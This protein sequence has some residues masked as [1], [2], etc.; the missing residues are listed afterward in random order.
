MRKTLLVLT[1]VILAAVPLL[2]SCD[3]AD[4]Q[5]IVNT[6]KLWAMVHDITD[7]DGSVNYGAAA[8]FGVGELF[9]FGTTGDDEGDAAIDSVKALNEIRQADDAAEEGWKQ[10]YGGHN[11]QEAVL[12][13]YNQAVDLRKDDWTYRNDRGVAYLED[14]E[15]ENSPK[16]A[17]A[18][19]DKAA[20]LAK[21]SKKPGEYLR[22]LQQREQ[23]M[24]RLVRHDREIHASPTGNML[25]EQ[26][27]TY[28]ELYKLTGNHDYLLLKQQADTDL[29]EGYYWRRDPVK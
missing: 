29:K 7:T 11:I 19:F 6:A 13:H 17:K 24:A 3:S 10:L 15:S 22:M 12:P 20:A 23:A 8:R 28:D 14:L 21:A 1:L 27:R 4:I 9:G 5:E 2:S 16:L 18:D 26:S 25:T